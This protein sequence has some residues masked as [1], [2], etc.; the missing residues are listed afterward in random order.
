MKIRGLTF[1]GS[2]LLLPLVRNCIAW[3]LSSSILP[4]HST[5]Q[6][7]AKTRWTTQPG[8]GLAGVEA[9]KIE[10]IDCTRRQGFKHPYRTRSRRVGLL[11]RRHLLDLGFANTK[12][13][14]R[15]HH[16]CN[17]G[18]RRSISSEPAIQPPSLDPLQFLKTQTMLHSRRTQ[19]KTQKR[20][21]EETHRYSTAHTLAASLP[22]GF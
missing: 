13:A 1:R 15:A 11:F 3:S 18:C 2:S 12:D 14:H 17:P 16:R 4:V 8:S 22:L 7:R 9:G 6:I 5:S 19:E 10:A 20:M 21:E